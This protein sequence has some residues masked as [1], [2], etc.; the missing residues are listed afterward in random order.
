MVEEREWFEEVE[1]LKQS[2]VRLMTPQA[3]GT[4]FFL[5]SAVSSRGKVVGIATAAHVLDNAHYWEQ[6]IR[7]Q[8]HTTGTTRLLRPNDR[9]IILNSTRDSAVLVF[10]MQ[11]MAFPEVAPQLIES[12]NHMKSGVE[13]GWLGFPGLLD[14]D[15]SFFS[16]H[17]SSYI[18]HQ[19]TYLVDGVA[20]NGVSGGPAFTCGYKGDHGFSQPGE[21][22]GVVSA[23][24][25]NRN[26]GETLPGLAVIRDVTE[27]HDA[28]LK[29]RSLEEAQEQQTPPGDS[30]PAPQADGT[31][32]S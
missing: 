17:I 22:I 23:Y 19:E 9:A 1:H 25:A 14:A 4:G 5:S 16:G 7:V 21:V 20:I 31:S 24:R 13:V 12:G 2:M 10:E 28:V 15:L 11:G 32:R 3:S 30:P 29:M 6:P 27:F 8:H 18:D 26:T